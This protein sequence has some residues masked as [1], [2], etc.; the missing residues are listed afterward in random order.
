MTCKDSIASVVP[1]V[2]ASVRT[3]LEP[4]VGVRLTVLDHRG[5]NRHPSLL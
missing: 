3:Q 5:L 1:L 4:S 2:V